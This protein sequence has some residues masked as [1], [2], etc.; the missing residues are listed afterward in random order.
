M[1]EFLIC[2]NQ[3]KKN[4]TMKFYKVL[5]L[6]LATSL[7]AFTSCKKEDEDGDRTKTMTVRMTDSPGDYSE[8]N[9]EIASVEAYHENKGWI[10]L[11]NEA[12]VITVTDLTNGNEVELVNEARIST[13]NYT[14][15]R[16]NFGDDNTLKINTQSSITSPIVAV[17]VDLELMASSSQK[18][19]EMEIN[20]TVDRNNGA[21]ILIDF[22]V[23]NSISQNASLNYQLNPKVTVVSN[24]KTGIRGN[25]SNSEHAAV[26]L[27]G[28]GN[29]YSTYSSSNGDFLIRGVASGMYT[30]KIQPTEDEYAN[31]TR[32]EEVTIIDGEIKSMGS[33][34]V[35]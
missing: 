28:N 6:G 17:E 35:E 16:L 11:N 25:I 13:G 1:A 19:I 2:N 14:K 15:L 30:L 7:L 10:M 21:N 29:S 31:E 23:A 9:V 8:L 26:I 20:Q 12:Q 4:Y 34:A 33:I 24:E 5:T 32:I 18:S 27:Q 3:N 22:D